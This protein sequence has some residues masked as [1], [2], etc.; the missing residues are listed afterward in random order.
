MADGHT[1]VIDK[2]DAG[3]TVTV[4]PPVPGFDFDASYPD[5]RGAATFARG[6]RRHRDYPIIDR[7]GESA[8]V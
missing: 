4:T 5:L 1:I 8:D 2:N 6:V 3:Y 7:T